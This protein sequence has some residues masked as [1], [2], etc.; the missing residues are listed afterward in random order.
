[1][2]HPYGVL[3]CNHAAVDEFFADK[4]SGQLLRTYQ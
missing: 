4:F 3:Q 2:L 1:M